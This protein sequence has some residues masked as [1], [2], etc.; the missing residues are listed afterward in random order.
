MSSQ[1][2]HI[3]CARAAVSI[4]S[5]VAG[6]GTVSYAEVVCRMASGSADAG[7]RADIDD[8]IET[9]S[10]ALRSEGGARAG[11]TV[12]ILSP[13][14][15]PIQTCGTVYCLADADINRADVKDAIMHTGYRLR[16]PL[17]FEEFGAGTRITALLE[18]LGAPI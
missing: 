4:V 14:E 7:M 15:P 11:K 6:C 12:L 17:Q 8:F 13:A 3:D 5:A 1:Q 18:T 16:Q 10:A 2:D 9:T